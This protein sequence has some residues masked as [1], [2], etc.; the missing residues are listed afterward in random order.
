M[1]RCHTTMVYVKKI[2]KAY[3]NQSGHSF[4]QTIW[5]ETDNTNV[6][7]IHEQTY[8]AASPNNWDHAAPTLKETYNVVLAGDMNAQFGR[9][10]SLEPHL[11]GH[12]G[13]NAR[14]T[15]NGERLLQLCQILNCFSQYELPCLTIN[16]FGELP[17]SGGTPDQQC[18]TDNEDGSSKPPEN[19]RRPQ[20]F[21]HWCLVTQ[22]EFTECTME[23][24]VPNTKLSHDIPWVEK[25][26]PVVLTDIVGNEATILRLT[27]FSREGNV[28]NI[29]I[30][31]PPGCGKTTSI[32]CL[33]HALIGSSYKE[34]V[35]ELNASNDRGI[36][37]V[38]NKIKMFAQKKV[39]LP[40][41]RQKIIILDEAD[42]MTEG[43]QQ[44]LRRT[45]EIY[46]R[47]TRFALACNDSSKLIEPIQSRCAV[48]R[49]ARLT[50]AQIMA[51]LLEVCRAESVS[52]TDEGLEAIVFT[53]DGDMRQWASC[54]IAR[55]ANYGIHDTNM[56]EAM[57]R[58][59]KME[60][61]N[62]KIGLW[63]AIRVSRMS[64]T[65]LIWNRQKTVSDASRRDLCI[66]GHPELD[67]LCR[68][69]MPYAISKMASDLSSTH[70]I[71]V[72]SSD[73]HATIMMDRRRETITHA[74]RTCTCK[75]F[76]QFGI[77][78]RH[79]L[80]FAMAQNGET[81]EL[82]VC[83]RWT[84]E[85]NGAIAVSFAQLDA[86]RSGTRNPS[87]LLNMVL[88]DVRTLYQ[89]MEL[90]HFAVYSAWHRSFVQQ[91]GPR[92]SPPFIFPPPVNLST[93]TSIADYDQL[94]PSVLLNLD[95]PALVAT[96]IP[97]GLVTE[98]PEDSVVPGEVAVVDISS[99]DDDGT[100]PAVQTGPRRAVGVYD[101]RRDPRSETVDETPT[102][103]SLQDFLVDDT[104]CAECG[105]E[106]PEENEGRTVNWVQCP[107]CT[108]WHHRSCLIQPPIVTIFWCFFSLVAA[109]PVSAE[110]YTVDVTPLFASH[111]GSR[112][113]GN[114]HELV[115]RIKQF[116]RLSGWYCSVRNSKA[117]SSGE[118]TFIKYQCHRKGFARPP[119]EGK[120]RRLLDHTH[121]EAFFNVGRLGTF[122][123]VTKSHMVHNH[124]LLGPEASRWF[125][126]NRR[127]LPEE[128]EIIR[129]MLE[130][131]SRC[132]NIRFYVRSKF[133]KYLTT[134]DI[135]NIRAR[136]MFGRN[137]PSYIL[138]LE[139][140]FNEQ[141]RARCLRDGSNRVT[142]FIYSTSEMLDL[143]RRFPDFLLIDSTFSTNQHKYFLYQLLIVDGCR[144]RLPVAIGFLWR[145][146]EADVRTFLLTFLE[147]VGSGS[148]V[149][150][151]ISDGTLSNV[152]HDR[153]H[154]RVFF[155]AMHTSRLWKYLAFL[156]LIRLNDHPFFMC[157][158]SFLLPNASKWA[159]CR[160]PR[161]A[162]YG[163][164]DTNMVEAMHRCLKIGLWEAIRVSRMSATYV[165]WNRQKTVSDASRRDLRIV[166][167]PELDRLCRRLMPYA[168]S[169]MASDLSSTHPITVMSSNEH[170]T[171]M[172]DRRRETITHATR[173]CTC[174][175]FVQFGIPC[176]HLLHFAMA[177]NG[178]T[179]ELPVCSRWTRENNGAIAVSFAQLDAARS[180]T[181]NP[182]ALLNMVL[183]DVRTLYQRMELEH[184]AVY[185]AWHRSFVQQAGPRESPPFIFPPPVNLSTDT[186][187]ADYDQLPP[188][189]LLNLDAPALVATEIPEGLVTEAPED[190]V[191]P[192]EVAVVDISSSDDDGTIPA[193][194]TGP[195][196]AVGVYDARRD[197]RSEV[198]DETP[199]IPSLQD[200][201]V[202]DTICAECGLEDPEENEGRTVNWVQC[203][204]VMA[205]SSQSLVAAA[206]VSAEGYTVDV[207]PLFAS[208]LGSRVF[209]NVHELVH[210]IK[211]FERLS[212][213]YYSVRNSK[214]NSSGEKTFIKYQCHRKGFAR[215]P[216]EGKRRRLL[217]HTHCEAFFNVGRLGTFFRVTKSHM[218]HNHEL[219]GPEAS[220]W[221]NRNRRLLPEELEIIRPML[222]CRSRCF[223]IRFYV[224]S[225]FGKYLTTS[226]I[227]NIRARHMFG[228]NNPSYI[229]DLESQFNEQGRARCLRD[230]SNRVTHFIYSTS[231]MLDLY[232][233]FPD[234][235]LI[236]STF[237]TNQHKYFLYQLL[238]VDGCRKS[239]PV[240]IGFL[241]RETEADVR[242]FL[243]TFL[244]FVGSASL[245]KC[246][247]S[248]GA[249]AIGNAI[250]SVFP[251]AYH[252][253][254]RV[255][256]LRNVIKRFPRSQSFTRFFVAMHTSRLW[257]YLAFLELIRLNDPPFFMY[258]NSFL[259]PNASKW[260][261]CRMP[262]VANYGIHDTNMVEAMHRCLKMELLNGKIGLWEAIRV[263]R[264]SATYLIWNRQETVSDAPRRDLC[265][266][267]H[268]ELDR[269]CRRLMPYAISKMASD[270][271]STHPITVMSSDEHATIMMDRRRETI[272]H[273]TRTCTCKKFVQFGIPCRHLLHFA[274]AQN[275]ET[276]ELPVC[277]RWTRENN[278]AI[279]V[280]FTPLDAPRYGMR[281]PSALLNMVLNDVRTLYQRMEPGHFA[282]YAMWHRSF[283]Q[284]A[285]TRELSP[286]TFPSPINLNT[287]TS[288]ADYDQLPPSTLLNL[289]APALL[290]TEIPKGLVT[291]GPEDSVVHDETAVVDIS[292]SD[293]GGKQGLFQLSNLARDEQL[294]LN[295][296]QSTHQGFGM[297]TS[298]NVFKVCDEPHPMLVK[299][300]LDHCVKSDFT[301]AHKILRHLWTLGYSAEDIMSILF[302]VL[303][304]HPMEEYIKLE[305]LKNMQRIL[306]LT[307]L[308][309]TEDH[310]AY[311]VMP[312]AS[313]SHLPSPPTLTL[314]VTIRLSNKSW[315][316]GSEA[317]VLNTDVVCR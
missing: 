268:P 30:A 203:T 36:D 163:I 208:H 191:V 35:L 261:S 64:A 104:I 254:C 129:P 135:G 23:S 301:E 260:A 198:V 306:R 106:D 215:P 87:A 277:S 184:F 284:Q 164:H 5:I 20:T 108:R 132:F 211:Q 83:S 131:R 65:Y 58:C 271:S 288:I 221:F 175:K 169:K 262:R 14:R 283:V 296:L 27:A 308:S 123:R 116:E 12:F 161:V 228:R 24:V 45:M 253:L 304:N 231:E 82:P 63:E 280:S 86:P 56:V 53:A 256:I 297:V 99:L 140:Q 139:S 213:W 66:V 167:H 196:R 11:G 307:T 292:S 267:G 112:V 266:V 289:D 249:L 248:D 272:T 188:S 273:A 88:N 199:T 237:S 285:G 109:A 251:F 90:E 300:L 34:A 40:P 102:V 47:T 214:A 174:K 100:I 39:T 74:T 235:L 225:K 316:Y 295:N 216:N 17:E 1:L 79:L 9:L 21:R 38:R 70:P 194:Q 10:S 127:L 257:K 91:A 210:C 68:R 98:A 317:S 84:R 118:K 95:A 238:I 31:G 294:A 217:D 159:S 223:N 26:R 33:A 205:S 222:E 176:R 60:L 202:D 46:S 136:H 41:G 180:G 269:L 168:I 275:V 173:T 226:D 13:I 190:S 107:Y 97:E 298:E 305:F 230:G 313:N 142:H 22:E 264:M 141:G 32:L 73:E 119:N 212:G 80:H 160:M 126:R 72:M 293:E 81:T 154:L 182:S 37:V 51:R 4:I 259:L 255:H 189:V 130:C 315:L 290:P 113:F 206:P 241:W 2:K 311:M 148:L 114:V 244:E 42:S 3:Y 150:C 209:G 89:R 128:L 124:E 179:T 303:K 8:L 147:F 229:L 85:N 177:Q 227:G 252:L 282:V 78:C 281:T 133:G 156:E 286:F 151:I 162:N 274:M 48:L 185:A 178:E 310:L 103:P 246:I 121:C 195:R 278:G 134:S 117:N 67:R 6:T 54:R 232:R 94:P 62:G 110:E 181:R 146:T 92:E 50:A 165:I 201:L 152:Y 44:A 115:H 77:P 76:V 158:N 302:R 122:F 93:D 299:Q 105:L 236:D 25:Y 157:I 96:E 75:K 137:N 172:M 120:R 314:L 224:R 29:I 71:T 61:L 220:R 153:N 263:S 279:A 258:I 204:L 287:D 7:D 166:G 265:I 193:V 19:R 183:N 200:F 145:E 149:K 197:P 309:T 16:V 57:H 247:M 187:I 207:T 49:Y 125:D 276:T 239:L 101:A 291:A 143:Y 250:A 218:V 219:L 15:G 155:V 138:D 312:G 242:T 18:L 270:L 245:V 144:K 240:A 192:G 52:Y 55:V 171:I 186:S 111:L 243:L 69:L 170:A 234:F 43:A 28:P 233:R 59:L